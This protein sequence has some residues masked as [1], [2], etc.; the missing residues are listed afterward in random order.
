MVEFVQFQHSRSNLL[1]SMLIIPVVLSIF[2]KKVDSMPS[3]EDFLQRKLKKF[4]FLDRFIHYMSELQNFP[5]TLFFPFFHFKAMSFRSDFPI[6]TN[7]PELIYLDSTASTQKPQ[8]VID[9]MV[10]Y[11]SYDYSNIHRGSYD[12]AERSEELYEASKR[13]VA[14][15]IGAESFYEIVYGANST[16]LFNLLARSFVRSKW[17]NP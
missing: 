5:K 12:I 16:S 14:S 3:H 4:F 13:V 11:L 17:L 2:M 10:R 9:A 8:Q 6:F 7:N 15:W 1:M